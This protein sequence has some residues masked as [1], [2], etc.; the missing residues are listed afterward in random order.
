[1]A[2]IFL[3]PHRSDGMCTIPKRQAF[4]AKHIYTG[5]LYRHCITET[6]FIAA[7]F[8]FAGMYPVS[9]KRTA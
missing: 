4:E 8:F 3:A 2:S 1:N 5:Q 6:A 9:C 7:R